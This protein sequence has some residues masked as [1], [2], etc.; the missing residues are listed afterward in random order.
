MDRMPSLRLGAN[1]LGPPRRSLLFDRR[2][3]PS[4]DPLCTDTG[5]LVFVSLFL[6][7]HAP[8][9][10]ASRRCS[11]P[12]LYD[13]RSPVPTTF[14]P[15]F[16][17]MQAFSFP[18]SLLRGPDLPAGTQPLFSLHIPPLAR[19]VPRGASL[20]LLLSDKGLRVEPFFG[21]F[22]INRTD[23]ALVGAVGSKPRERRRTAPP[24]YISHVAP[25]FPTFAA[26]KSGGG[27]SEARIPF[28]P[29]SGDADR[30]PLP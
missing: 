26:L 9:I 30:F 3:L 28:F 11:A 2:A 4:V 24:D 18:L 13:A 8:Y 7:F 6:F 5:L 19:G 25:L 14:F 1:F 20:S 16:W 12:A 17:P 29:G 23:S 15:C 27:F 22:P 10:V 21:F